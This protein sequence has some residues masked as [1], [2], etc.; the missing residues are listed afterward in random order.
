MNMMRMLAS[1]QNSKWVEE[2]DWDV[3][4]TFDATKFPTLL[5]IVLNTPTKLTHAQSACSTAV[6]AECE[7]M[8]S[9][10]AVPLLHSPVE[11]VPRQ[12]MT[13]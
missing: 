3:P 7:R 1:R 9:P 8:G 13:C 6:L 5:G 4:Y 12:L 11:S 10:T 2:K